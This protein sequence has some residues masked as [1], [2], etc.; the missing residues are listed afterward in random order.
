MFG[1]C[2]SRTWTTSVGTK[3]SCRCIGTKQQL[4]RT[5]RLRLDITITEPLSFVEVMSEENARLLIMTVEPPPVLIVGSL[6]LF[7]FRSAARIKLRTPRV[8]LSSCFF[9]RENT[10]SLRLVRALSSLCQRVSGVYGNATVTGKSSH[11]Y[12]ERD[13]YL[14]LVRNACSADEIVSRALY[15]WYQFRLIH[16]LILGV[17]RK[18]TH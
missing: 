14:R 7:C 11:R 16:R 1:H 4:A 3:T 2:E 13:R 8:R 15:T 10:H 18:S 9:L 5:S 17:S 6:F 12:T